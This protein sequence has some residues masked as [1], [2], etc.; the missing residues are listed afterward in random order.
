[1]DR[2][3]SGQKSSSGGRDPSPSCPSARRYPGFRGHFGVRQKAHRHLRQGGTALCQAQPTAFV[4][5]RA[6]AEPAQDRPCGRPDAGP[7]TTAGLLARLPELGLLDC[8]TIASLAGLAPKARERGK[9][10]GQRH[11]GAGQE[12]VRRLMCTA[13]LSLW[14]NPATLGKQAHRMHEAG[15]SAKVALIA[16][17]RKL[18]TIANAILRDQTPFRTAKAT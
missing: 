17:A 7:V 18:L 16:L 6:V 14:R 8:R 5:R 3:M 11:I 4:P 1:M 10:G 15:N 12:V 2:E 9:Y 13:A